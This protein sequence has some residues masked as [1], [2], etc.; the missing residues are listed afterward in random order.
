MN[1]VSALSLLLTLFCSTYVFAQ[2][3]IEGIGIL[4]IG[5]TTPDII[6]ELAKNHR[7]RIKE[8]TDRRYKGDGGAVFKLIY[9]DS[10]KTPDMANACPDA[11]VY[12]LQRY[13][14]ADVKMMNVY[15]IFYEGKLIDYVC[16]GSKDLESALRTKYGEPRIT[17]TEKPSTFCMGSL[18]K[19]YKAT[20]YNGDIEAT[21]TNEFYYDSH[22]HIASISS[23]SVRLPDKEANMQDCHKE[24]APKLADPKKKDRLRDF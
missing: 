21:L 24:Y 15:L 4:K 17:S 3:K 14:V 8:A 11:E 23:F 2:D 13:L 22:C 5:R 6:K 9:S 1:K 19:T 16:D 20:W 18:D 12:Y 10:E 7:S